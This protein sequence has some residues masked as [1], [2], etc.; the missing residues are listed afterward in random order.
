MSSL[1]WWEAKPDTPPQWLE[2]LQLPDY[3]HHWLLLVHSLGRNE[4][5]CFRKEQAW[6]LNHRDWDLAFALDGRTAGKGARLDH[7]SA[8]KLLPGKPLAAHLRWETVALWQHL[9]W[10]ARINLF[11]THRAC[12]LFIFGHIIFCSISNHKRHSFF[13]FHVTLNFW[14]I[15]W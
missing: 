1:L 10:L 4:S 7:Q 5:K 15:T 13:I 11:K 12:F 14:L 8:I 3:Q 2:G 6:V 9:A